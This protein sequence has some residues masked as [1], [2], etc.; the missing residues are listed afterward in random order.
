M[1]PED[2]RFAEDDSRQPANDGFIS[3]NFGALFSN[4]VTIG[5]DLLQQ[6]GNTGPLQVNSGQ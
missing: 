2:R 4:K 5:P 6:M 3:S 1:N